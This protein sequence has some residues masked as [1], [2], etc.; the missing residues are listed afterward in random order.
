VR[1]R[2]YSP[3]IERELISRLYHAARKERVPMTVLANR[4]IAKGLEADPPPVIREQ[5]G[6]AEHKSPTG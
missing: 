4:L 1:Q 3:R 2:Y 5:P 6:S